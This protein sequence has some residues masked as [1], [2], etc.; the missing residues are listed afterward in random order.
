M[1]VPL[2]R[3]QSFI[4]GR[5]TDVHVAD[6]TPRIGGDVPGKPMTSGADMVDWDVA[7]ATAARLMRQGPQ[8][9]RTEA[10]D[11]V[12]E[13]RR[14]AEEAERHVTDFTGLVVPRAAGPV[15]V[16]DRLGWARANVA[17]MRTVLRPLMEKVQARRGG[18]GMGVAVGAK[19]A[20][21]E[22]GSLMAFLGSRVLGQYEIFG[23]ASG[24]GD[25]GRLLLI[26]P[27]IVQVEQ[28]LGVKPADFRL[29]VCVHEET[30]RVQFTAVPWLRAHL[31]GEIRTFL[32]R[33]DLDPTA[34][35][36]RLRALVGT[37]T[38][39]RGD[40]DGFSLIDLVQTPAQREILDRVTAVMSLLEG[41]AEYVMDGVGPVVIPTVGE[42]RE[43]FQRRRKQGSGRLDAMVRRLL[44]LEEKMRQYADGERFVRIVVDRV[45]MEGFNRVWT[46]PNTLPTR[47][48][49]AD[50][51]LWVARIH[52]RPA[53]EG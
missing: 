45:G 1:A 18:G 48:E 42:I 2:A 21:V 6:S 50:P 38:G 3:P 16:V 5:D 34:L 8:T 51:D 53:L 49:I 11:T 27:N 24:A 41:H 23:T 37:L 26:A 14:L 31:E 30:H 9:S 10:Q 39:D 22:A 17:G 15:L 40:R 28:D 4:F 44:G 12:G 46:S 7:I 52:A 47:A 25:P 19:L 20:G 33:T 43:R 32:D 35:V 36:D 29:W 13:L